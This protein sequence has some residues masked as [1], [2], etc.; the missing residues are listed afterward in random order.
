MLILAVLLMI[1]FYVLAINNVIKKVAIS[2]DILKIRS[3]SGYKTIPLP[4][5]KIADAV[6][7]QKRQFITISTDKR[8]YL[9]RNNLA[10][11]K[12]LINDLCVKL[13]DEKQGETL[14]AISEDTRSRTGDI[15]IP[16]IIVL[17]LAGISFSKLFM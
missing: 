4:E 12:N 5:I 9:L 17:L 11:F 3:I 2:D 10:G 7:F 8:N 14:R 15:I 13:P 6:T 16:W 1:Y